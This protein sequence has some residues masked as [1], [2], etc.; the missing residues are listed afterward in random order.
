MTLTRKSV[1][2]FI[3]LALLIGGYAAATT[4]A[5]N[6][7]GENASPAQVK[8]VKFD[9]A[10]DATRFVFDEK[11]VDEDGLP[12]YGNSFVTQGYIYPYGTLDGSNGVKPN[13]EPQFPKKVIGE[14]TC[15]GWFVGEGAS[16]ESGPWVSTTQLYD[17]GD[18]PGEVTLVTDGSEIADVGVPSKR[19][20]TG[21]TGP[22]R[23][24][25][26]EGSQKL[27]GFNESEGVNLRFEL[28]VSTH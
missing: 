22:Y 27:L 8:T 3:V 28:K 5:A 23:E 18:K 15:R 11:P 24:A 6:Q 4:A 26:G 25:A 1:A 17:L 14:W 7:A 16:T 20:I 10:E 9:V 12:A 13:G 19:A 2:L 21:G